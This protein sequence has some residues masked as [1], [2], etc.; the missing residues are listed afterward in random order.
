LR[1]LSAAPAAGFPFNFAS[2]EYNGFNRGPGNG[3]PRA[4][5][6]AKF[7][8]FDDA[9]AMNAQIRIYLGIHG[10]FDADDGIRLGKSAAQ[11]VFGKFYKPIP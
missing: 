3:T 2:D 11:D 5:I 6:A 7:A 8:S 9:R 10:Q 1:P 4:R